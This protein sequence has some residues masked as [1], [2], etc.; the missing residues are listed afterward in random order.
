MLRYTILAFSLLL[1]VHFSFAQHRINEAPKSTVRTM[2]EWEEQQ[3]VCI[4]WETT[5]SLAEIQT[6]IVKGLQDEVKV[7]IVC[8]STS[9]LNAA[10]AKLTASGVDI[11]KNIE[12]IIRPTNSLWIRDYGPNCV[13]KNDVDSLFLIDWRYNRNRLADD[14]VSYGVANLLKKNLFVTKGNANDLINTGGNFMSDG[15]GTAFASQLVLTEN[16]GVSSP[17]FPA[18]IKKTEAEIDAILYNYMGINRYIKM[19]ILPND[20]IHHIDMHMKLLDEETLLMGE[21]P[22]GLSDGPQIEA[23][24]QYIL[25]N[26]KTPYGKPYQVIRIPM[27]PHLG[28]YPLANT[29]T[30]YRT[31][32]NALICNKTVIVPTYEPKYDSIGLQIWKKALPGHRIIG[33]NCN[34]IIGQS[35]ALHCITKEIGVNEPLWL[36][37]SRLSATDGQKAPIG[38]QYEAKIKAK[39]R[40]GVQ[41]VTLYYKGNESKDWKSNTMTANNDYWN[42][43]FNDNK[44]TIIEYY[45]EAIANNGK[46]MN[47][48]ITGAPG[49]FRFKTPSIVA[50]KTPQIAVMSS[51]IYP[52]PA[53]A[54]TCIALQMNQA[55][56]IKIELQN[57]NGQLIQ[58]IYDGYVNDTTEQFFFDASV[59]QSGFYIVKISS[60]QDTQLLKVVVQ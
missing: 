43:L 19:P 12:F 38:H 16:D 52:N 37:H 47:Y 30:H 7:I 36:S 48:P 18:E 31:Y 23:N 59:L 40:T 57:M 5:S 44:D 10:K 39:H 45:F 58:S 60:N 17:N 56:S 14:T 41:K 2:A 11:N 4:A 53:R 54:I 50:D 51:K 1:F 13:Y 42:T 35:G 29:S 8:H 21:Y 49:A 3:A 32:A 20:L 26:F 55:Q 28:K 27:P 22:Q 24:L 25:K 15:Q 34:G 9:F 33:I 46:K 6:Q